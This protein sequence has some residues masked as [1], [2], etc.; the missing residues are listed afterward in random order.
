VQSALLETEAAVAFLAELAG[1]GP[2]LE[3][4]IG[5]GRIAMPLAERGIEICGIDASEKMVARLRAKPGGATIPVSFG[6][7][8]DVAVDGRYRLIYVVFNTLFALQTQEAQIRCFE[9]VA[10]HLADEG[11]FVVEAFVP[12]LT[13]FDRNQRVEVNKV[14]LN[15]VWLHA[16]R[17]NPAEQRVESEVVHLGK[18]GIR[19]YPVRIRYAYPSELDLMAQLGGLRLRTRFDD[20][21]RKP[22]TGFTGTCVSVYE[23]VSS[24]AGRAA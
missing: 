8:A 10:S 9:N 11:V 4:A 5:T 12:D 6:D 1:T 3:L 13:R 23:K 17:H 21:K 18:E 24:G 2:V 19:L 20:W 22:Y 16:D 15:E 14:G 7:F